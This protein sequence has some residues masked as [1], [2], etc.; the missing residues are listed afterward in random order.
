MY[1]RPIATGATF[2]KEKK[3]CTVRALANAANFPYHV[4]HDILEYHGRRPH[5][6]CRCE[7][8][9]PAYLNNGFELF[10]VY[11]T[12]YAALAFKRGLQD[13][14]KDL[15]FYESGMTLKKFLRTKPEGT[16][17][18]VM[19]GHAF[20]IIEGDLVDTGAIKENTRICALFKK[21]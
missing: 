3:D 4:A 20:T 6:G 2:S 5:N 1:V 12:T 11:G 16:Y 14:V 15:K 17:I 18:A 7:H 10:G 9:G 13:L 8:W 19:R 21:V